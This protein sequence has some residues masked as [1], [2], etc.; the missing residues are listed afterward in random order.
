MQKPKLIRRDR[1]DT[2]PDTR[3]R[4]LREVK[5]AP[6]PQ[7]P[8]TPVRVQVFHDFRCRFREGDCTCSPRM[9]ILG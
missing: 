8:N 6:K 7:W 1:M 3:E 9:R 4:I 2:K 5:T